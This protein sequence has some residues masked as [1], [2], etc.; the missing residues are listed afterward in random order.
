MKKALSLVLAVLM[1]ISA[2]SAMALGIS[3]EDADTTPSGQIWEGETDLLRSDYVNSGKGVLFAQGNTYLKSPLMSWNSQLIWKPGA[4]GEYVEFPLQVE[5]E[6]KKRLIM[7][8]LV[9]GDLGIF[10]IYWDDTLLYD[11]LDMYAARNITELDLGEFEIAKGT[12][13]LKFVCQG[14]NSKS[15]TV[16][17][18]YFSPAHLIT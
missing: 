10:D 2:F 1:L 4:A 5:T 16:N 15:S 6:G 8:H 18:I 7:Q 12:H 14:K 17:V 9:S 13:K 11:D 3:A